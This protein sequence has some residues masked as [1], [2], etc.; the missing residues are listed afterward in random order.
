MNI[1]HEQLPQAIRRHYLSTTKIEQLEGF[2][3]PWDGAPKTLD[4]LCR[5]RTTP[6]WYRITFKNG[7]VREWRHESVR[8]MKPHWVMSTPS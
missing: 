5:G 4:E 1:S 8:G 7:T 3:G 6:E 2:G